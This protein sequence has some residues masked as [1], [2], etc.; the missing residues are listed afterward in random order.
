MRRKPGRKA[1]DYVDT[2]LLDRLRKEDFFLGLERK[3]RPH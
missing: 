2:S 3:Y 1:E